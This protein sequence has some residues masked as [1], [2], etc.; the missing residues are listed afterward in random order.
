MPLW[1]NKDLVLAL[2]F[3]VSERF[4][5]SGLKKKGKWDKEFDICGN[6]ILSLVMKEGEW[7][8]KVIY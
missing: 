1:K 6:I 3:Q 4:E 8:V 2:E 7:M 5:N